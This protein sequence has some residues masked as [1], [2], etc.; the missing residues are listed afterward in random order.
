MVVAAWFLV[1]L[2]AAFTI[3][4]IVDVWQSAQTEESKLLWT[5]VL[6]TAP[7]VGVVLYG[8]K[9]VKERSRRR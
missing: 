3:A 4:A 5:I 9:W 8:A 7:I 6:V 1:A 2:I